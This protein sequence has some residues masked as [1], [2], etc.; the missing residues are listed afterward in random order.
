[1]HLGHPSQDSLSLAK[2]SKENAVVKNAVVKFSCL[3]MLVAHIQQKAKCR[4]VIFGMP[5]K[6]STWPVQ[7][8]GQA[9]ASL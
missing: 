5:Q 4:V 8:P 3:S 6:G 2:K 7:E 1:M 9:M